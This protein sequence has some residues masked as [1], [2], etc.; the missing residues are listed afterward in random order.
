M[1][2]AQPVLPV[3]PVR[4]VLEELLVPQVQLVQQVQQEPLRP[5]SLRQVVQVL[6]EP[7]PL[8]VLQARLQLAAVVGAQEC[9]MSLLVRS[10]LVEPLQAWQVQLV[11]PELG[12]TLEQ[13]LVGA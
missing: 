13:P 7:G 5:K 10:Q 2:P 9:R 3:L 11:Q 12:Q 8:P 4:L 6:L 1:L